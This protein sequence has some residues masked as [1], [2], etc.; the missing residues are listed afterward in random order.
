MIFSFDFVFVS[1]ESNLSN[2][3]RSRI[4][5]KRPLIVFENPFISSFI[6]FSTLYPFLRRRSLDEINFNIIA[7]QSLNFFIVSTKKGFKRKR[8]KVFTL[9]T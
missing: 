9:E 3:I 7:I 4:F 8:N 2:N 6:A 5:N 1:S